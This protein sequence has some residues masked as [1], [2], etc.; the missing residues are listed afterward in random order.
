[1]DADARLV[2]HEPRERRALESDQ[3]D[4]DTRVSQR[5]RVIL[6]AGAAPEIG[7]RNDDSSHLAASARPEATAS[8]QSDA[9]L[10]RQVGPGPLGEH[11]DAIAEADQPENVDEEPDHPGEKP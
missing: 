11:R 6:H 3:I 10:E 5:P 7:E 9:T 2:G 1:M 8:D 4:I